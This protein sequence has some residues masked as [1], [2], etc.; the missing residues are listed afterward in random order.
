M[1]TNQGDQV[2][3]LVLYMAQKV[4]TE[5]YIQGM[6]KVLTLALESHVYWSGVVSSADVDVANGR[7]TESDNTTAH[8]IVEM[9]KN[10]IQD[11]NER[12]PE[13]KRFLEELDEQIFKQIVLVASTA[14]Q[15]AGPELEPGSLQEPLG[16]EASSS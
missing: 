5:A 9:K 4:T 3:K 13:V 7:I 14:A 6:Q 2:D 15:E 10:L 11:L 12:I 1:A 16:E 8:G